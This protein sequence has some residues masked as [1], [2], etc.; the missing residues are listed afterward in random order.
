MNCKRI[1]ECTAIGLAFFLVIFLPQTSSAEGQS[2]M[3]YYIDWTESYDAGMY[4]SALSSIGKAIELEPSNLDYQYY[5]AMT[6]SALERYQEAESI[7]NA[8]LNTDAKKYY[9]AYFDLAAIYT[10]KKEYKKALMTISS[11]EYI[12]PDNARLYLEKGM[13]FRKMKDY[14]TAEINFYRALELDKTMSQTVNYNLG[15]VYFDK[16]QYVT[17]KNMFKLVI[18]E[19]ADSQIA[20]YAKKAIVSADAAIK[21]SK[22]WSIFVYLSYSY[23]DNLSEDPLDLPGH[24]NSEADGA[25]GQYQVFF[26]K[27]EYRLLKLNR[28]QFST[29]YQMTYINFNDSE[30]E[31]SF[32]NSPYLLMKYNVKPCYMSLKYNYAHYFADSDERQVQHRLIPTLIIQEPHNMKSVLSFSYKMEDYINKTPTVDVNIWTAKITQYI[33][34]PALGITPRIGIKYGDE[35]S[36]VLAD[37]YSYIESSIGLEASL[38]FKLT[39]DILFTDISSDYDVV[40]GSEKREDT[41]YLIET[42]LKKEFSKTISGKLYYCYTHNKSN[43]TT[44]S[45]GPPAYS[46]DPYKYD[47]NHLRLS[48]SMNF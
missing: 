23:D 15:L 17:S 33:K 9:K 28:F 4:Q 22:P 45:T 48:F 34:F 5:Y 47:E 46:Y 38:P 14:K 21:A 20:A 1:I 43:V 36:D 19:K 16:K 18:N 2:G 35:D 8:I 40:I 29:G 32:E 44:S 41:G 25:D 12:I 24:M 11:A 42:F 10:K 27:G 3:N 13:A 39:G 30:Q 7:Y 6:Y 37:S 31:N 26:L